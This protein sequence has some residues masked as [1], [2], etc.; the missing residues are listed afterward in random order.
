MTSDSES[1]QTATVDAMP[2]QELS[3]ALVFSLGSTLLVG[4][5]LLIILDN[6]WWGA[7]AGVAALFGGGLYVGDRTGEPE[8][9]YGSMLAAGYFVVVV[10]VIFAGTALEQLPDPYPGLQVGNSTFFFVAPLLLLAGAV[11]GTIAGARMARDA[12]SDLSEESEEAAS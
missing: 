4:A 6:V 1:E 9:L 8:P 3:N 11:A 7:A 5:Y 2:W 10:I 12:G